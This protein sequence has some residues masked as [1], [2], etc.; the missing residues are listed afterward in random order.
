M[1]AQ[2][3]VVALRG[4]DH[5]D[6]LAGPLAVFKDWLVLGGAVCCKPERFSKIYR[7]LKNICNTETS[8]ERCLVFTQAGVGP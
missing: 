4:V 7:K 3:G 8:A 1:W 5:S 6:I 2:R